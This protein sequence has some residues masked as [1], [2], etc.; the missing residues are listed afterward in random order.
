MQKDNRFILWCRRND[1]AQGTHRNNE[2]IHCEPGPNEQTCLAITPDLA[3]TVIDDVAHRENKK[4]AGQGNRTDCDLLCFKKICR[5]EANA[6][7]DA[8]KHKQH[9]HRLG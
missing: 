4:T 5:D 8:E 2:E 1:I 6:E 9:T 3:D 7:E